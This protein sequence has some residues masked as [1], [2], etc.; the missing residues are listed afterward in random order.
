M[1]YGL[2][3]LHTLDISANGMLRV[4][5]MTFLHLPSVQILAHETQ[6]MVSD[7]MTSTFHFC[8]CYEDAIGDKL[9]P[10]AQSSKVVFITLVFMQETSLM[11]SNSEPPIL[12]RKIT[13]ATTQKPINNVKSTTTSHVM[14]VIETTRKMTNSPDA[15]QPQDRI[16][17]DLFT[18]NLHRPSQLH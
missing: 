14:N 12:I 2:A 8:H 4:E 1:F 5:P 9:L 15:Y 3:N 11:D 16:K 6:M 7:D 17:Y 13:A 10:R 18:I